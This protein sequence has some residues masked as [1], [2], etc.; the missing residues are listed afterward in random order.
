MAK[1]KKDVIR[2]GSPAAMPAFKPDDWTWQFD[3]ACR[4][5]DTNLFYY[6]DNERGE[7]KANKIAV[8]KSICAQCPVSTACLEMAIRTKQANG[9]WGGTTPEER[10]VRVRHDKIE[11]VD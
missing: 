10:G 8:A 4:G 9:I 11:L 5:E 7:M 2:L 6:D 3:A 1:K